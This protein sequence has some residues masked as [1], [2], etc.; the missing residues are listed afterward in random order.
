MNEFYKN[1]D[2]IEDR[3][4]PCRK[5]GGKAIVNIPSYAD[6]RDTCIFCVNCDHTCD[7]ITDTFVLGEYCEGVEA[8]MK[9]W[10]SR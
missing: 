5:C 2:T 4:L 7:E 9:Q 3:L 10:N 1:I 8:A 6:D